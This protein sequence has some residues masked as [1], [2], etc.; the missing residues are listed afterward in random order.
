MELKELAT[1]SGQKRKDKSCFLNGNAACK[2]PKEYLNLPTRMEEEE[3]RGLA[4]HRYLVKQATI[5]PKCS[6]Q[7]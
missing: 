2:T 3:I 7:D 4:G 5:E 1:S 6:T